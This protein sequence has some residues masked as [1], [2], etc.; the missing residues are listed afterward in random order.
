[1]GQDTLNALA[2]EAKG[3]QRELTFAPE[4]E[5]KDA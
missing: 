2:A 1:M 3:R 5:K 4:E